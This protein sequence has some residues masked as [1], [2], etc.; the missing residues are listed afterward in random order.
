MSQRGG[1]EE[2]RN[3]KSLSPP[4][5]KCPSP[6]NHDWKVLLSFHSTGRRVQMSPTDTQVASTIFG[7]IG[8]LWTGSGWGGSRGRDIYTQ[9]IKLIRD[10]AESLGHSQESLLGLGSR[11]VLCPGCWPKEWLSQSLTRGTGAAGSRQSHHGLLQAP[12]L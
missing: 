5:S 9:Y 3:S 7:C 12:E 11:G 6:E 2:D 10:G 4:S 1:G 8:I